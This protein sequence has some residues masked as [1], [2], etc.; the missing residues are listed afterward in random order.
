MNK[1]RFQLPPRADVSFGMDRWAMVEAA[2]RWSDPKLDFASGKPPELTASIDI[3]FMFDW[4]A[5]LAAHWCNME[6]IST[7]NRIVLEGAQE[8]ARRNLEI[9]R[10]TIDAYSERVQTIGTPECPADRAM[11]QTETGIK[12]YED[13]TA[14]LRELGD[15]IQQANTEAMEVLSRRC[16]EVA[17]EMKSLA[18]YVTRSFWDMDAKPAPIWERT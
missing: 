12:T 14:N 15:I 8:A 18:R 4:T 5:L 3:P 16:T 7:A 13:A 10:Q 6:A 1:P 11:R 17:N 2:S 9:I